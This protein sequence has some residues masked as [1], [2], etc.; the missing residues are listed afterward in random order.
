MSYII[1]DLE[2]QRKSSSMKNT[3]IRR[4]YI[5]VVLTPL[6]L[7][8]VTHHTNAVIR[9]TLTDD[10]IYLTHCTA[11]DLYAGKMARCDTN[12]HARAVASE[13]TAHIHNSRVESLL[14]TYACIK[15]SCIQHVHITQRHNTKTKTP[16]EIWNSNIDYVHVENINQPYVNIVCMY[17]AQTT[18]IACEKPGATVTT[19][20][21]EYITCTHH[22]AQIKKQDSE[23]YISP[24]QQASLRRAH[25]SFNLLPLD[26]R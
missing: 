19:N 18:T 1:H 8:S 22:P 5:A 12:T 25:S 4:A 3:L 20:A 24:S 11:Y 17:P 23:T 10:N 13:R 14:A 6:L 16:I 2:I 26:D 21:P 9:K 7:Q 15:Y